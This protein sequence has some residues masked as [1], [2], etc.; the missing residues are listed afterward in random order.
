MLAAIGAPGFVHGAPAVKKVVVGVIDFR[1]EPNSKP[2]IERFRAALSAEL[3]Q[4][5]VD[6]EVVAERTDQKR[7][8][9]AARR[10]EARKPSIYYATNAEVVRAIR[11]VNATVP[12][13]FSDN[14]DPRLSGIVTSIERPE[15]NMTGFV[16]YQTV[17][18][19]RIELLAAL[20][21]GIRRIGLVL[22][23][24]EFHEKE[25][26]EQLAY[27]RSRGL[28]VIPMV[29]PVDAPAGAMTAAV[30]RLRLDAVDAPSS[31]FLRLNYPE[32]LR[33]A[34][35][36]GLPT[37]FRSATYV[38]VGGLIS[39]APREFSYPEKAAT[40]V[41]QVLQGSRTEDIPIEFPAEFILGVN[42]ATAAKLPFRI[43]KNILLR[44]T[45]VVR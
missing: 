7:Y 25:V 20:R 24:G 31:A 35:E 29:F 32:L 43:N 10:L 12:I 30:R 17:D 15:G 14:F 26:D 8:E 19:K 44:A 40:I 42:L 4:A 37:G 1:T 34:Q 22:Q 9:E 6:A 45:V 2:F 16:T 21:P 18:L 3:R 33:V 39:Y 28:E 38:Q 23:E 41:A 11:A 27:G 5:L 13:V 36:L